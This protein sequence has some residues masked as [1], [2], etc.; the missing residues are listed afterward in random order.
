MS[1]FDV[2]GRVACVTGAS[3]GLGRAA[4][5]ML[6]EAGAQVVGVARREA[7]LKAWA[8]SSSGETAVLAADL[9]DQCEVQLS[10]AIG[11]A[12]PTSVYI[13]TFGTAKC[14]EDAISQAVRKIFP[15]TPRG[16]IETL[17]LRKPIYRKTARHGHFGRKAVEKNGLNFFNWEKTDKADALKAACTACADA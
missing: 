13:D 17:D 9:A 1:L 3:S 2:K 5:T 16:I 8:D 6:A 10:Y 11:V 15:L 12:E 14:D 7:E 4:A